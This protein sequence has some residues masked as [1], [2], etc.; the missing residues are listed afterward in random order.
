MESLFATGR[1]AS[2]WSRRPGPITRRRAPATAR[3]TPRRSSALAR[4]STRPLHARPTVSQV[5]F[6]PLT[7]M[8]ELPQK[9]WSHIPNKQQGKFGNP[10]YD[11]WMDGAQARALAALFLR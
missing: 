10:I 1:A 6:K 5:K 2:T 3:P 4:S 9:V 11:L 7:K 8:V